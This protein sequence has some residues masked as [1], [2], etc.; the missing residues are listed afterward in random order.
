MIKLLFKYN[1]LGLIC[2][3]LLFLPVDSGFA[4]GQVIDYLCELGKSFYSLGRVDDAL[5]EFKKALLLDPANSTAKEYVNKIFKDNFS[6]NLQPRII[7]VNQEVNQPA[8][9]KDPV[10]PSR[11][12]AMDLALG[13]MD[14]IPDKDKKE[15]AE[16]RTGP[17]I[18]SGEIQA[19][20]GWTSKDSIWRRANWDMNEKNF[21]ML[22]GVALN[23]RENTYDAR[24][25][26]RLRV[27]LDTNKDDKQDG[28]TFHT[29][30][31]FD[32]WSWTGK[33]TK[34]TVSSAF[35][36]TAEVQLK[37]IAGT[38]YTLNETINSSQLGN[39][40]SLPELKIYS[41]KT[42]AVNVSG[43]FTP[44]DTFFIPEMEIKGSFMP[45]RELWFDY[46][47]DEKFKLR[48]Y[49]LAYEN[50]ALT[51]DDP[52]R[53]S[54]NRIW[55][56]DSPWIRK[57]TPGFRNPGA[58]PFDFTKGFWDKSISFG[59]RDS[60][61]RR[62]TSL[63]GFS[64]DFYP[65][66]GTN[67]ASSIA[68]PKDPWQD[69]DQ[70]DN[71]ISATRLKQSIKDSAVLG[72]TATSRT[73]FN[74]NESNKI[75]A[76]NYVLAA[77]FKYEIFDGL[78]AQLEFAHSASKYDTTDSRFET[79]FNGN[80]YYLA[81]LGRFPFKSI[82]DAKY[83]Y[84]SIAP[85]KD[86]NDFT[87]FRLFA[88]RMDDSFDQ[89]L[90]SYIE[91]R[92]DE[93]WGRHLQFRKPFKNYYQGEGQLLG[94]DDIKSYK[95]GTGIDIGRSTLG[96]RVESLLFDKRIENL[97]DVRNVHDTSSDKFVENVARD[98]LTWRMT[99]KLTTKALGIYQKMP[100]TLGGIDPFTINSD[101]RRNF[102][103]DRVADGMNASLKTGSLGAEYSFFDWLALNGIW[104][105]T[106][107]YYLGYDGFPRSI[108]NS[109]NNG[110]TFSQNGNRYRTTTNFLY[111]QQFFPAPPYEFYNIFKTGLRFNPIDEMEI[112]LDYTRNAY[113]KAGQVSDNM[114]HMGIEL[115]YTPIPKLSIFFKYTYS[116][117][118]DLDSVGGGIEKVTGHHN[119]FTEFIYR[120]SPDQDFTFQYGEAS[121]DPYMGGVLDIG[122]DPYGG[123]LRTIDTQHILRLYYRRRF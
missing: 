55:W 22:S 120:M 40:F 85:E 9:S 105:H 100:K 57:W 33:S 115:G 67:F 60:E 7:E 65:A 81:L 16:D 63:R 66:E 77:D 45:V 14:K 68:T 84:D 114:N 122:W 2:L 116:R 102:T 94:W 71:L 109:G 113:R 37:H 1:A 48:V 110:F 74:I 64:F 70:A 27:N 56:E 15:V 118:Q 39:S 26:D 95:I 82:M 103:N 87:K 119:L 72:L 34:T 30:L 107:D 10:L 12:N 35:G 8:A 97:F 4:Q 96:M 88:S 52:L 5:A 25:Y 58:V 53:L 62:L 80:A 44:A 93:W 3:A 91:T 78:Q 13:Q 108:F 18:I 23:Q 28:F 21:R 50:Q 117:W 121:R 104:E 98:E 36:D 86:E 90:S 6:S 42:K 112:Y 43:A 20:A 73:G 41:G 46:L 49:P 79:D 99:D 17:L 47:Q 101:T 75:D 83:G 123:S 54:N 32:P 76:Q 19:R 51:F 29:N 61:G 69:Y 11:D 89:P 111:N 31:S 106:N 59:L 92:D 24:I 38:N